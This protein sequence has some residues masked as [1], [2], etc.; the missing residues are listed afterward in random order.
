MEIERIITIKKNSSLYKG[1][2]IH[3]NNKNI[4]LKLK[5]GYYVGFNKENISI[6]NELKYKKTSNNTNINYKKTYN[7]KKNLKNIS[8]IATGGTISCNSGNSE[9]TVS[10]NLLIDDI[11]KEFPIINKYANI[12]TKQIMNKL[13]ENIVPNVWIIIAN[14]IKKEIES[15]V[16]GI[17]VTCGTDTMVYIASAISFMIDTPIPI[18][19]TGSQKS[20]DRPSSDNY[21]NLICS[22]S[23][24]MSD[25]SEVTIVMHATISDDYCYV[26][27]AVKTKKM[28]TTKRNTFKSINTIPIAKVDFETMK[29]TILSKYNKKN[30]K[31]LISKINIEKKCCLIKYYPGLDP[32]IINYYI[33]NNYKGIILECVG[34]GHVSED[35]IE[36][37]KN[38]TEKNILIVITSQCYFGRVGCHVYQSGMKLIESGAIEGEDLLPEVALVKMMWLF[39]NYNDINYIKTMMSKNIRGEIELQEYE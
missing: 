25:I 35:W 13:S 14:E 19:F 21:M 26:H 1:K 24:A 5:N 30:K 33:E 3:E 16:D 17:I 23:V 27:R 18:V 9:E 37:I 28:H 15:G 36:Y 10:P 11:L 20:S 34:M 22:L 38:A 7:E 29:I 8:F 2:I 6:V 39:G 32:K 4:T 12:K 31:E